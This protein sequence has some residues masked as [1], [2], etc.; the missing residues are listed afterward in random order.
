MRP[1][2]WVQNSRPSASESASTKTKSASEA[3]SNSRMP[4]RPRAITHI[5]FDRWLGGVT[6]RGACFGDGDVVDARDHGVR[7]LRGS[8]KRVE[9][10]FGKAH[11]GCL[12]THHLAAIPAAQFAGAGGRRGCD[13]RSSGDFV[14]KLR[15]A[16]ELFG[17]I[18]AVFKQIEDL[19]AQLRIGIQAV[20]PGGI[21]G[22]ALQKMLERF[23]AALQFGFGERCR[24]GAEHAAPARARCCCWGGRPPPRW[25]WRRPRDR[26]SRVL[27]AGEAGFDPA[28]SQPSRLRR[29]S[30]V[31]IIRERP[32]AKAGCGSGD[33]RRFASGVPIGGETDTRTPGVRIRRR[34]GGLYPASAPAPAWCRRGAPRDRR[35]RRGAASTAPEIRYRGCRRAPVS[36]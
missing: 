33:R 26:K 19:S 7:Q 10:R 32:V 27:V 20:Q 3:R 30:A 13:G 11:A 24:R 1:A 22:K 15:S 34:R 29:A 9:D 18:G 4:R 5:S 14:D 23:E 8:D 25:R 28:A 35:R 21:P 12:N 36:H 6:E 31:P 2:T 17:E 16:N